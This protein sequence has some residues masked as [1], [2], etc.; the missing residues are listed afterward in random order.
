MPRFYMYEDPALNHRWMRH[1]HRFRELRLASRAENTAEVGLHKVLEG[2][3]EFYHFMRGGGA[4][5][6]GVGPISSLA[7]SRPLQD[8]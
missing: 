6:D 7:A 1:C 4:R 8:A 5:S 3:L 2:E